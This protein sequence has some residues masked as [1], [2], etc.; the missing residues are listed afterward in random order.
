MSP[1]LITIVPESKVLIT[2]K[3]DEEKQCASILFK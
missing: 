2:Y 1:K 3:K